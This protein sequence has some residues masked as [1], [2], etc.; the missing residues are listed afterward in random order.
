MW[1]ICQTCAVEHDAAAQ[2]CRIC[3]DERQWM[4][5]DGQRWTTLAELVA[6]GHKVAMRELEPD[7]FGL[8]AEPQV[9]IGQESHLVRTPAGNLLWDVTGYV[10]EDAVRRV[11]EL[12]EVVAIV[13][14]HPHHYGV[15][16]EWSRALGGVPVLVAE[17]DL[18]WVARP[19]PVIR[20]W[21]GRLEVLPGLTLRQLGGHFPGSA[22]A[23]WA[24]GAGGQGVLFS[25]DTI[26]ANPD[27]KSV[28][29][30]RSYPNR[31]P[32]S[33]NVVERVTKV[34]EEF[35]FTRLYDNFGK[36]LDTDARTTIRT[37]AARYVSWV[38]GDHDHLT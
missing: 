7:L 17:A 12:G 26:Q 5:A 35:E 29:F 22:V 33:P 30:M 28:A 23:H 18:A 6:A 13:P 25:A 11:R 9:G 24:A 27:R 38:R 34:V 15:Q 32:L 2:L 31:I 8:T 16:V 10:D 21:S 4:P 3:A 37:S 36:T 20:P 14:S 1:K 19:D